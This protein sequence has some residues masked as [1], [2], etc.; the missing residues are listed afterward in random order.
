[1][2]ETKTVFNFHLLNKDSCIALAKACGLRRD[3]MRI[4]K[5]DIIAMLKAHA[6]DTL[7]EHV[8]QLPDYF[9]D[10]DVE[11]LTDP[12]QSGAR[13][14]DAEEAAVPFTAPSS[15]IPESAAATKT[16]A[17]APTKAPDVG[18]VA[19][20]LTQLLAT[21]KAGLDA[22]EVRGIVEPLIGDKIEGAIDAIGRVIDSKLATIPPRVIEVRQGD[23]EAVQIEGLQHFKFEPLLK[24]CS[25]RKA[26]GN[27]V[28]VW[29]YGPPGTGKTTAAA[30][31]AKALKLPFYCTGALMSKYDITGFVDAAGKLVRTPFREAWEHGGV[32]LFDEID[33]S[34][35][36]AIVAFNAALANGVMAFPDGMVSRHADCVVIAAA[37]TAGHGA[38][39]E[40][41]GRMKMD[42][43][44]TDRF[45]YVSWPVD[46][47]IEAALC[48]HPEW[49][50]TV[51]RF[52]RRVAEVGVKG[53][54]VTPRA[55]E[56]GSALLDQGL[57]AAIVKEMVLRKGMSDEQWAACAA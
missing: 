12:S 51:Q 9:D 54:M 28:N 8:R 2:S 41:V 52:R 11:N 43:A 50:Q 37:N 10:E 26:D 42:A 18:T 33:G 40:F 27:R 21:G 16:A 14:E 48:R 53:V 31:V 17:A 25:A 22:D 44:S 55:T 23:G 46:E 39:A 5:G 1:M 49:A 4:S 30:N 6:T 20:L 32:Y 45:I 57:D 24:A 29:M 13:R 19:A 56:H 34:D 36:R 15:A 3:W 38:T 47:R 35:P 7:I